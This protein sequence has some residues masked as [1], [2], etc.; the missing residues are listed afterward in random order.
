MIVYKITNKV[1]GKIYIGCTTKTIK[2]RLDMHFRQRKGYSNYTTIGRAIM[3]YGIN[4][5]TIEEIEKLDTKEEMFLRE[6]Y[7]ISYYN[8]T[9]NGVGYNVS[10]GGHCGPILIGENN[11]SFGKKKPKLSELNKSRKGL[12]LSEEHKQNVIKAMTGKKRNDLTKSK[13]STSRK[14]AWENGKYS[15]EEYIHKLSKYR[16]EEIRKNGINVICL[17]NGRVYISIARAANDLGLNRGNVGAVI[18]GKTTHTGGYKFQRLTDEHL[19][20]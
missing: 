5:F 8:S 13:M 20:F 9:D 4:N 14:A 7:W 3:K 15:G 2:H 6:I 10:K 11:P 1:N 18:N 17:N 12:K 16:S 19:I